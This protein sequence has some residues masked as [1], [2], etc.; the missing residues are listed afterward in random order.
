M[1][2]WGYSLLGCQLGGES[3]GCRELLR[4]E[5]VGEFVHREAGTL[6]ADAPITQGTVFGTGD[7]APKTGA[8]ST[9]HVVFQGDPELQLFLQGCIA[10]SDIHA[11]RAAAD[12]CYVCTFRQATQLLIQKFDHVTVV[13]RTAVVSGESGI[14]SEIDKALLTDQQGLTAGTEQY[15]QRQV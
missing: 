10:E 4:L 13:T 9:R 11:M 12:P 5:L 3:E 2:G 6:D 15:L 7:D 1:L 14:N 8:K